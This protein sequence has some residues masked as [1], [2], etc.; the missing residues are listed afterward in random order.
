MHYGAADSSD[1]EFGEERL[2]ALIAENRA[3]D[4]AELGAAI[5]QHVTQFCREDFAD[6]ATLLTVTVDSSS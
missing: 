2:I 3:A 5:M 4:A 6:D 1:E